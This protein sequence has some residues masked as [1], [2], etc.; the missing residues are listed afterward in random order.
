MT[1]SRSCQARSPSC[2]SERSF[3]KGFHIEMKLQRKKCISESFDWAVPLLPWEGCECSST[4]LGAGR[5]Q[6]SSQKRDD[7][8]Y[9][10]FAQ[11][12]LIGRSTPVVGAFDAERNQSTSTKDMFVLQ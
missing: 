9:D 5:R 7:E 11:Q 2:S 8:I 4:A 6:R 3:S 12:P 10:V 1:Q